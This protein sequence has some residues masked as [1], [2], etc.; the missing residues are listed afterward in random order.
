MSAA[1]AIEQPRERPILF[2]APMV[3]A[4]LSGTKTQT[5]RVVKPQPPE[6]IGS[7][8]VGLFNPAIVGRDGELYPAAEIFG[9][10]NWDGDWGARCPYGAP[11]DRLWVRETWAD[12]NGENGP[13]ISY[14]AGGDRFLIEDSYPV[15]YARYPGGRF[16]MWCGDLRRGEPGHAWR[17]SIHMPRWASRI[18]LEVTEVR[19]ERLQDISHEGAE[20]EGL[21]RITKD[22]ELFKY[23]I[24]DRDGPPGTDDDG[25]PWQLWDID[26]RIAFKRLWESINGAGSWAANPWV[27][28]VS[29]RRA[30]P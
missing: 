24:A 12:T 27:W 8:D 26:A 13:M 16:T 30:A 11:G 28:A 14:R 7:V 1:T 18:T 10:W 15:D 4:I 9:A 2:S 19:A 5:R 20:A 3:R 21:A 17:P 23:G 22:G 6:E 25:R 29:F